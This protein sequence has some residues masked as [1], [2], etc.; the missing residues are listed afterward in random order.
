MPEPFGVRDAYGQRRLFVRQIA[1]FGHDPLHGPRLGVRDLVVGA[2]HAAG[3]QGREGAGPR[4]WS[5]QSAPL[6]D[7]RR[8][9]EEDAAAILRPRGAMRLA[10]GTVVTDEETADEA[11]DTPFGPFPKRPLVL[12]QTKVARQVVPG[13]E[14]RYV[15]DFGDDWTYA[16]TVEEPKVDPAD[17]E[18][19]LRATGA[20]DDVVVVGVPDAEWGEVVVAFVVGAGGRAV[21]TRELDA[22]CLERIARFKRPK[23]YVQLDGLPKN[24][25]GKVLKTELRKLLADETPA[26]AV[27]SA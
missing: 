2:G 10:D 16:C 14:F 8:S 18:G 27:H 20:F 17:V 5:V 9:G 1:P 25:Y 19:A 7:S 12:E 15:F 24:N 11:L 4:A 13:E 26:G 22:L 23:R 3:A 21:P 6:F